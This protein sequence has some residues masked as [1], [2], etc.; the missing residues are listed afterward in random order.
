[1]E[2]QLA[3]LEKEKDEVVAETLTAPLPEMEIVPASTFPAA[4]QHLKVSLR[5]RTAIVRSALT[6]H[7]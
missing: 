3:R 2:A 1:V 6:T 5:V 7:A 4:L